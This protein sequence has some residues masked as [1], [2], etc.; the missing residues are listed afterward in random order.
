MPP[1]RSIV[2]LLRLLLPLLLLSPCSSRTFAGSIKTSA[3]WVH[4]AHF[5]FQ[6]PRDTVV[7]RM[8]ADGGEASGSTFEEQMGEAEVDPTP[9]QGLI[10]LEMHYSYGAHLTLLAYFDDPPERDTSSNSNFDMAQ[11]WEQ[12]RARNFLGAKLISRRIRGCHSFECIFLSC[13]AAIIKNSVGF[14]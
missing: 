12:V 1:P 13:S 2:F 11:T 10:T 5:A 6:A 14:G 3:S 7:Y 8:P 4:L 9:D